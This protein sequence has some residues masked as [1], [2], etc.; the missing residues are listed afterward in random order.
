MD[1]SLSNKEKLKSKKQIEQ[2]FSQGK[3][4]SK[5][6]IKL[7][8]APLEDSEKECLIK[9]GFSVPKRIVPLAIH[10][11]KCKRLLREAYRSNKNIV[12]TKINSP[13]AFM[14]LYLSKEKPQFEDLNDKMKQLLNKFIGQL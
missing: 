5:F 13:H 7:I 12:L 8:Y 10:R 3:A 11:N 1:F 4:L 6:P 14:F 2:L 9:V